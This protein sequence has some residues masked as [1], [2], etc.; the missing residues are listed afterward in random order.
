MNARGQPM[1]CSYSS[2]RK[3]Y[4]RRSGSIESTMKMYRESNPES[5]QA[6][7]IISAERISL[8]WPMWNSPDGVIPEQ[9]TC[10]LPRSLLSFSAVKSAQCIDSTSDSDHSN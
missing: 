8:M 9:A 5:R 1:Y 2:E 7:C 3:G 10:L 4:T 6:L